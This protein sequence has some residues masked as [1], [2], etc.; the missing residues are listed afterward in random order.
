M[1]SSSRVAWAYLGLVVL[2]MLLGELV[3]ERTVPTLL[4]AYAPP[5][6]WLLPAPAVLLWAL[7]QRRGIGIALVSTLLAAWGA[8]LLNVPSGSGSSQ[9][10]HYGF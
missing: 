3:A 10:R 5:L 8:D 4:L 6:L 1:R 2:V 7:V 9:A